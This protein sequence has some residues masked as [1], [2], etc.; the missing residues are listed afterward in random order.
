MEAA[1]LT[2]GERMEAAA[3]FAAKIGFFGHTNT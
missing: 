1:G 3:L 2:T